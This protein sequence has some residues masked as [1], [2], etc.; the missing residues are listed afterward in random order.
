MGEIIR[1]MAMTRLKRRT[2]LDDQACAV[3]LAQGHKDL[4]KHFDRYVQEYID[5]AFESHVEGRI[6]LAPGHWS[7]AM[8]GDEMPGR[9][10]NR[11]DGIVSY[12]NP[13]K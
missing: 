3:R 13:S 12:W 4:C 8:K 11:L 10:F 6:Y 9:I 7:A 2:G 1:K 5:K